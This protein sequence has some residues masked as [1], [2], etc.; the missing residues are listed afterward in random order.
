MSVFQSNFITL[1]GDFSESE[2]KFK[3]T[4]SDGIWL[5]S[6]GKH[7]SN[8]MDENSEIRNNKK[9]DIFHKIIC[10]QSSVIYT[11]VKHNLMKSYDDFNE[12]ENLLF[13]FNIFILPRKILR[14]FIYT[15]FFHK[16]FFVTLVKLISW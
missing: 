7:S 10:N 16:L 1:S 5:V 13:I 6:W 8:S 11:S 14:C 2:L 9:N 15:K 4:S 12:P 3:F